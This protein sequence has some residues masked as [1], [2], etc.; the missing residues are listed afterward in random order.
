MWSQ[1]LVIN[2]YYWSTHFSSLAP[3]DSSGV[4]RCCWLFVP[5]LECQSNSSNNIFCLDE[6][7]DKLTFSSKGRLAVLPTKD[8][9]CASYMSTKHKK[10]PLKFF[11]LVWFL[12]FNLC[13]RRRKQPHHNTWGFSVL[14]SA[15][16]KQLL[17]F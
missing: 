12:I 3:Q 9:L 11:G 4:Y 13:S 1:F 5:S 10:C 15:V 7:V 16:W 17:N 8:S 6:V 2:I 14:I